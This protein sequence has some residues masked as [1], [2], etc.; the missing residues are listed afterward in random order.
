MPIFRAC[1]HKRCIFLEGHVGPNQTLSTCRN[2]VSGRGVV[3]KVIKNCWLCR[4]HTPK[5]YK[6]PHFPNLPETRMSFGKP[7]QNCG[8]DMSGHYAFYKK[9]VEYKRYVLIITCF[10]TRAVQALV[11]R[12]NRAFSF[13]HCL[14]RHIYRYGAPQSILT[15][16]AK[17]FQSLNSILK[18][19]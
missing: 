5:L 16:N 18:K 10:S 12:D 4:L 14:R 11:C 8:I 15:D 13:I 3:N 9:G 19:H 2:I 6:T 17:N 7:F 1:L